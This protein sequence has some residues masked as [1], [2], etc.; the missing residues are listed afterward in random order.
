MISRRHITSNIQ[1]NVFQNV[2]ILRVST[3]GILKKHQLFFHQSFHLRYHMIFWF[4]VYTKYDI[5]G[6]RQYLQGVKGHRRAE[7]KRK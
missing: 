5:K 3:D 2:R 6:H 7:K 4:F 1:N